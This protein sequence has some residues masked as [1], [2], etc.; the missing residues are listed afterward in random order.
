VTVDPLGAASLFGSSS[1][2]ADATASTTPTGSTFGSALGRT[3]ASG[4]NNLF[5]RAL[6]TATSASSGSGGLSAGG[7]TA[8]ASTS[9]SDLI[10]LLLSA[11]AAGGGAGTT[12]A[13]TTTGPS[14]AD[15]VAEADK[16]LGTPYVWG[17]S[18]PG[19]FD[20]SGLVQYVYG[21]LGVNLPRTSQEQATVGTAVSGLAAAQPGDLIFF[22]G[23]DG[24]A[25]SPGHVGIYVGNGQMLDAPYTGT[26]VQIEAVPA[27]QVVDIRRVLPA[28]GTVAATSSATV[29]S[30][31]PDGTVT[32]GNVS[33]PSAYAG[34]IEQAA[35]AN[36]IPPALLAALVQ[37][38]S[39]FDPNAVSPAGAEGIAQ[40]MPATAAGMG[41]NPYDPTSAIDGA[42]QLLG[43]Y[44]TQFGSYA[45]ALA[46]Y[47]AGPSAVQR[48]GG[49]PPYAETQ[50]YVPAILA[51]AG[52]S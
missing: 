22:A 25:S 29:P 45:D 37:H 10:S 27:D 33:V 47:N 36:G 12:T 20:C 11:R 14:G 9:G 40:F 7:N 44:T 42:A 17:G 3:R 2:S 49:I 30:A 50:A 28:A 5:A 35:S 34:T 1:T 21:Q 48:Y 13:P 38:E 31:G 8:S 18:S 23:S 19:G 26:N 52:L 6:A 46:A 43:S 32:M 16:F 39:G 24:T 41:V 51:S 15:A 4:P